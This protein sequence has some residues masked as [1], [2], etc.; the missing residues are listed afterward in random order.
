[1]A[2]LAVDFLLQNLQR[3]R[4]YR[5]HLIREAENH[6]EMLENNLHLFKVFLKDATRRGLTENESVRD[7]IRQINEVVYEAEDIIDAVVSQAVESK[8]KNYFLGVFQTPERLL[9]GITKDVES[10]GLKVK[11]IYSEE[12]RTELDS[13]HISDDEPTKAPLVRQQNIVLGLEDEAERIIDYL[14]EEAQELDIISIIGVAGIGKTT[15][16]AKVFHDPKIQYKF[17][18][19]IWVRVSQ[20]FTQKNLFLSILRELTS[21]TEDMYLRRNKELAR[22]IACYLGSKGCFLIVMDDVQIAE[23]WDELKIAFP[24]SNNMGKV[25][26]TSR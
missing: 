8:L 23:N 9:R 22:L 12:T 3:V 15:L 7:L 18:T 1:M 16:A 5:S 21:I 14:K 6:L 10:V 25:L 17:R 13:V 19:R 11:D 24:K 2:D 26:I 4:L 20:D